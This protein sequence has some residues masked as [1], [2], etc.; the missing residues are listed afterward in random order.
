MQKTLFKRFRFTGLD[1]LDPVTLFIEYQPEG[2]LNIT[3]RCWGDAWTAGFSSPGCD[4]MLFTA[5]ADVDYV[6]GKLCNLQWTS[7]Q[8]YREDQQRYLMRI[9]SQVRPRLQR[10]CQDNPASARWD[11]GYDDI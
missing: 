7:A 10:Y 3:L 1:G 4:G 9:W 5:D 8:K 6:A 2:A 11:S